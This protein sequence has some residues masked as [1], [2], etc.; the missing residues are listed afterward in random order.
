MGES[1]KI[2]FTSGLMIT[3]RAYRWRSITRIFYQPLMKAFKS[4]GHE[5]ELWSAPYSYFPLEDKE[6]KNL[7]QPFIS[8][9]IHEGLKDSK[10]DR[11]FIWNG[12]SLGDMR[13]AQIC[14]ELNIPIT[15]GELGWF[16]QSETCYF[17]NKGTGFNSSI[18]DFEVVGSIIDSR[19]KRFISDYRER[20]YI[21]PSRYKGQNYTL[22]PLQD[23][24][25][26]NIILGSSVKTM[27]GLIDA[28]STLTD[29][30][31]VVRPHPQHK[32]V[33]LSLPSNFVLVSDNSAYN[34]IEGAESVIGLNSTMLLE[35][36][37]LTKPTLSLSNNL[38]SGLRVFGE[39]IIQQ[40]GNAVIDYWDKS[41]LWEE[42]VR[43][44]LSHMI[45][46]RMLY[47]KDLDNPE[48][49]SNYEVFKEWL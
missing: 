4:L 28:V 12:T 47:R 40:N 6:I 26:N 24:R 36:L 3:D 19:L 39:G 18:R 43:K 37:L 10:P 1:M 46:N 8:R 30:L 14:K 25:D 32:D 13:L 11:V 45:F 16:P 22:L 42:R 44:V 49:I 31:V 29:S 41:M 21:Q 20:Y 17:D 35:S 38:L 34:W 15:Y 9:T 27:Q 2:L 7:T 5:C 48:V 23:E 33:K